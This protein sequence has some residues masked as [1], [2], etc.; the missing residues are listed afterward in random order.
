M[1]EESHGGRS[2]PT[3]GRVFRRSW[4]V[5]LVFLLA[6]LGLGWLYSTSVERT[7]TARATVLLNPLQANPLSPEVASGSGAQLNIALE[8]EAEVVASPAV[9]EAVSDRLDR[10]VPREGERL[11]V[12]VPTGT[13]MISVSFTSHSPTVATDSAQAFAEEFLDYRESRTISNKESSVDSLQAQSDE[14]EESLRQAIAEAE[15]AGA[16]SFASRQVD[17]YSDRLAT[18]SGRISTAESMA[19]DPGRVLGPAEIPASPNELPRLL[20]TLAAGGAGLL[21]G[22]GLV[23][24]REW[25]RDTVRTDETVAVAGLPVFASVPDH[26]HQDRPETVSEAFRRLRVGVIAKASRPHVLA[27]ASLDGVGS[28][29]VAIQLAEAMAEAR[30]NVAL[31]ATDPGDR[32]FEKMY[33]VEEG[34][35]GLSDLL[36]GDPA[37]TLDDV[38]IVRDRLHIVPVGDEAPKASELYAGQRLRDVVASLRRAHDYVVVTTASAGTADGDAIISVADSLLIIL[39]PSRTTHPQVAAALERCEHLGVTVMGAV[40]VAPT[41]RRRRRARA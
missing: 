20:V 1:Y 18:I 23:W 21:L 3:P 10:L 19:T 15:E 31:L 39:T 29:M 6:G 33:A 24:Y 13:Q 17:L 7:Y 16:G 40:S 2:L 34:S 26:G 25:R 32:A 37:P 8:T 27:V 28:S 5:L 30:Y 4:A 22:S 14:A 41:G 12:Q 11:A 9:A 36:I 38:G 35:G